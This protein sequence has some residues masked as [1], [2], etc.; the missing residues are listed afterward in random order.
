MS[1][2]IAIIGN[3]PSALKGNHGSF[4]DG[5]DSVVRFNRYAIGVN[6]L[7]HIGMACTHWAVGN[8]FVRTQEFR[9]DL[10]LMLASVITCYAPEIAYRGLEADFG[11]LSRIGVELCPPWIPRML[12]LLGDSSRRQMPSTG[13]LAIMHFALQHGGERDE[14]FIK[15]FDHFADSTREGGHHYFA[16]APNMLVKHSG[17]WERKIVQELV[18]EGRVKILH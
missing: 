6:R 10:P 5:C 17:A 11:E 2:R 13:L 4:I 14:L 8:G 1:R 18:K 7:R 3:G 15:G 12:D 9:D 16:S